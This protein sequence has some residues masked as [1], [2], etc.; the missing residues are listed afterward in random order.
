MSEIMG[1]ARNRKWLASGLVAV[2]LG[3]GMIVGTLISGRVTAGRAMLEGAS[4]T[5]KPLAVPDPVVMSTT[6][7]SIVNKVGPAV[8]NISSTQV[9]VERR[10]SRRGGNG[11]NGG[12]SGNGNGGNSGNG[13]GKDPLSDYFDRFFGE[14][15]GDTP[16]GRDAERS[17]GSGVIVD[18]QGYILT[19]NHVVD[20]A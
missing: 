18:P 9:T 4:T 6:F 2:T 15:D 14:Q 13:G 5:V 10:Q 8:V 20:Q 7:A 11:A 19:N 1:W 3:L 16:N 12:N 17:L